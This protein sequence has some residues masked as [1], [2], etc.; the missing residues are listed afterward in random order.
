MKWTLLFAIL[1]M[2][3]LS[4]NCSDCS[5]GVGECID[6]DGDGYG[7]GS[8]CL[9]EDCDDDDADNWASCETCLDADEDGFF[10]GCDAYETREGPDCDDGDAASYPGATELCDGN[11]NAC[12]GE[13]GAAEVDDDGDGYV[14]CA[15]WD[16][17]QGDD[18]EI[19]GGGDCDD[20]DA[21]S[22]P[23]AT[24]L[25]D[26]NDNACTGTVSAGETD[27]DGDG[28]V[29]C[30]GWDDVQGDD[31]DILGGSDCDDADPDCHAG[32]CCIE[33]IDP[34]GDGYGVGLGCAGPDCNQSDP[35]CH[36]GT[37]C[38]D[39]TDLDGDGYGVGADCS[40]PDCNDSDPDCHEG[41]CCV[42]CTDLDRDGY[43][44]GTDCTGP[45]C[46]DNDPDC[47]IGGCCPNCIDADGDD[48][49][50]GGDCLGPDCDD[51]DPDC[52]E[53]DCCLECIDPDG[54]GYGVGDGCLGPDCNEADP[55]CHEGT[56]CD[57]CTDLD[58]DG[59]G[60]GPDCDGPDCND[61]DPDCH[62]GACCVDCADV[63]RDG[64]GE[65]TDC[66]GP[67]C[68]DSNPDIHPGADEIVADGIDQDCD[69]F[70]DCYLDGDGDGYGVNSVVTDD[71]LDCSNGS[72]GESAVNNDCDDGDVD[73]YP[74]ADEIVADG[75]DQNCDGFDTCYADNDGDGHGGSALAT[76]DDLDCSNGSSGESDID[77]DCDDDDGAAY[78]GA[79][80]GIADGIDQDCDG[81]DDCYEDGDGDGYG[82]D[83]VVTDDDLDCSNGSS[84]ESTVNTDC[85]DGN[86]A[87]YPGATEVVADGVDQDCDG[88]DACYQDSDGDGYGSTV[89]VSDND[90]DCS[91]GSNHESPVDTD[92]DDGE[93]AMFPGNPEICTDGLDNN[94]D[95]LTDLEDPV[96]CPTITVTI[97][98]PSDPYE[99][100]HGGNGWLSA[101]ID[102]PDPNAAEPWAWSRVWS[103]ID[104]QPAA[105]CDTSDVSFTDEFNWQYGSQTQFL[106]PDL[107]A[108]KDCVYTIEV[109]VNGYARDTARVQ[110][111]NHIPQ[112]TSVRG[113]SFDGIS[114][115]LQAAA[116]TP[117][118]LTAVAA[119]ADGDSPLHFDW[120]GP[121]VD[122]LACYASGSCETIDSASPYEGVQS[123]AALTAPG[124][125]NLTVEVWDE[126]EPGTSSAANIVLEVDA[127]VWVADPAVVDGSGTLADPR[128]NIAGALAQACSSA[129]TN[130]CVIGDFTYGEDLILPATPYT[131]DLLGGFDASGNV[132]TDRPVIVSSVVEGLTFAA[133]HA[134]KIHHFTLRQLQLDATVVT[135]R[136]A[137]PEISDCQVEIGDGTGPIGV[138][139][140]AQPSSV[141][142]TSPIINGGFVRSDWS[143]S[144]RDGTAVLVEEEVGGNGSVTIHHTT[145]MSIRG[146][147]GVC[148][149]VHLLRGTWASIHHNQMIEAYSDDGVAIAIH[150]DGGD[151]ETV[152]AVIDSNDRISASIR[153]VGLGSIAIS[154]Q[155]SMRTSITNNRSV[156]QYWSTAGTMFNAGIADGAV[157]RAGNVYPGNSTM[158]NISGN[159]MIAA[160]QSWW[161]RPC[162][163]STETGEGADVAVGIVLVGSQNVT[164]SDNGRPNGEMAGIFGG[165]STIHWEPLRRR[166]PP[167]A[168]GMW[169]VDTRNVSVTD[170]E[171]RSGSYSNFTPDCPSPDI[172]SDPSPELPI[173]SA[174]L[175]GL[176]PNDDYLLGP[177]P[178][179]LPSHQTHFERNGASCA[180][181]PENGVVGGGVVS[182]C[183]VV[184]LNV[185]ETGTAPYLA[186]NH[187][188]ATKGNYLI[189]LWQRGGT[190]VQAVNNTLDSDLM[191]R[192]WEPPPL[193]DSI[194]KWA[195]Y[196]D[197]IEP[198][199]LELVNNLF[200]V[201][202]DDPYDRIS[203]RLCLF[204]HVPSGTDSG[205]A[206]LDSNLFY[207]EGDDLSDPTTPPYARVTSWTAAV[208]YAPD[209][210]N[211]IAGIPNIGGNLADL[212][213]LNTVTEDWQK[214]TVR[215]QAG[216]VA[217]DRGTSSG[218]VPG[219]DIDRE[220]RPAPGGLVDIGHDEFYP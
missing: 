79:P 24:E 142:A 120:S 125:Y 7:D 145:D 69:G 204:E 172:P 170:N 102:P 42:D 26:G 187:L 60:D 50:Q 149:A 63:D 126:F 210:L 57:D 193:P 121:D 29:E 22:Y 131:P 6:L 17:L 112:I 10:A 95:G 119:D 86:I 14:E 148:R 41:A 108:Q 66:T 1:A 75:I 158:L 4:F 16:D 111:V 209:G 64:Y 34:D 208:D 100:S 164:I 45:D 196:A 76:D 140:H 173:G 200:Y 163:S 135:V 105:S 25:C 28:Y 110:M 180:L 216:S 157:D 159:E 129:D 185:P 99:I 182:W 213:G 92:C 56:C 146:C 61:T 174:Y 94:C 150:L 212:P 153:N 85:D 8:Q 31:P 12:A 160:S 168:A 184:Q 47:H 215:L 178:G 220:H 151:G 177:A 139:V 144:I 117:L 192:P 132:S 123:L 84:G 67:D 217:I 51:D 9:G 49:G 30:D 169:L 138:H 107:L 114:W 106:M 162:T 141:G 82:I 101:T 211:A 11:D 93:P 2:A 154:L 167:I 137:S 128:N 152:N 206:V 32:A 40:G 96:A 77:D 83:S 91:N 46:D 87:I 52:H 186:N 78:P 38:T 73:A 181:P 118:T 68:D 43:G 203:E 116:G 59:Y 81:F 166:L 58:G 97:H 143:D 201:H 214:S 74:G 33:C 21:D 195:V 156:G 113:A 65:G 198:D 205:I 23:G 188:A 189:A 70:D 199:G 3:T 19:A 175:D 171:I 122:L 194:V 183:A 207:I 197:G 161:A 71:D 127:C 155:E 48:Y 18:E 62:E 13:V 136:S 134:G 53:G 55:A 54:D 104:A 88:F 202:E 130:V 39:C 219:D 124:T 218:P 80:E 5:E 165:G 15:D 37:C 27:D 36:E 179:E 20:T 115:H 35:D 44:S 103:V 89:V 191:M 147:S 109:L 190:G 90:L 72:S 98:T 176:P 133:G